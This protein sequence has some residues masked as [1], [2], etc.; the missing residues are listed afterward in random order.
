MKFTIILQLKREN[1]TAEDTE[2][3]RGRQINL[4]G[5]GVTQ[6]RE[7]NLRGHGVTQRETD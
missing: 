6:S 7:F 2:L 1:L 4:R 3:R 5:H